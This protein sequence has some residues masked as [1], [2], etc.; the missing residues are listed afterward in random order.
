M[1]KTKEIFVLSPCRPPY[2]FNHAEN[3]FEAASEIANLISTKLQ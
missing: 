1:K 3:A 2:D